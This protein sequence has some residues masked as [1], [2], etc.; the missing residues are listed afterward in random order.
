MI[1]SGSEA[2]LDG[3]GREALNE[4]EYIKLCPPCIGMKPSGFVAEA[5]RAMGMVMANSLALVQM[6]MDAV[7]YSI[8]RYLVVH[9]F[10]PL[11]FFYRFASYMPF[12]CFLMHFSWW[13]SHFTTLAEKL[14]VFAADISL[15]SCCV[16]ECI[17][18]Q[19]NA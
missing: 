10:S 16:Y 6:L 12:F 4:E 9:V 15:I 7:S 11:N 5:T 17:L 13:L 3:G 8:L 19:F 18:D 1:L 2:S 14:P